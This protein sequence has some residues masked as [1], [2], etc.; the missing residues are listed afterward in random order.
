MLAVAYAMQGARKGEI[1]GQA[2]SSDSLAGD[3][4]VLAKKESAVKWC[5]QATAHAKSY[6]G[7]PWHYALIPHDAIR[8]NMTLGGLAERYGN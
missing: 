6:G 7:K 1:P 4:T 2:W 5:E 8:T 3:P